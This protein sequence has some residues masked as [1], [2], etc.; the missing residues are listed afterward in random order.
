MLRLN[1]AALKALQKPGVRFVHEISPLQQYDED[2]SNNKIRSDPYQ[3]QVLGS[4]NSVYNE[5]Y[6]YRRDKKKANASG[7]FLGRILTSFR[8]KPVIE[9]PRGI[10]LH[11]DVGC[12]KT[13]LMDMFYRTIP[14]HLTKRRL[15]F[16][17]FMQDMHKLIHKFYSRTR[18]RDD[19]V[20]RAT[21]E[22]ASTIDVLCLDEVAVIDVADAMILRHI[23]EIMYS[24]GMCTFMTSNRKPGEL[25]LNGVQRKSFLPATELIKTNNHVVFLDSP[26]DYRKL[27]R[28]ESGT[29]FFASE[30]SGNFETQMDHA[31]KWFTFFA[32]GTPAV[33]DRALN[34]WGRPV[35]IP[36]SAGDNVM[37][38]TFHQ[39]CAEPRSAADYLEMC[40]T[41][42]AVVI[43]DIPVISMDQRDFIRRFITF[44]DA[45][46]DSHAKLAV[47]AERPFSELFVTSNLRINSKT[48]KVELVNEGNYGEHDI[49]LT[50]FAG[51]EEM[52]AF[53]RALSRLKQM[54][55]AEWLDYER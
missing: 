29:Y 4:L 24:E 33:T 52:F 25:Y 9:R 2:V 31:E 48:N 36:R 11:G 16:H 20:V 27:P 5:L 19:A 37:Q 17:A 55:S 23:W 15:H 21:H 40:R 30:R 12:G 6:N 3:R 41:F 50:S 53:A 38:F 45:A 8:A 32:Q 49:D 35:P 22:I 54:S 10:Y 28:P 42:P 51:H 39:L 18:S 46:Y 7:G 26:T 44:L 13:M 14:S 47:T 43:T 34:I 1:K